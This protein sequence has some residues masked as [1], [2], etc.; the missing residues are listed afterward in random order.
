MTKKPREK[1]AIYAVVDRA[2]TTNWTPVYRWT[3][4]TT[5]DFCIHGCFTTIEEAIADIP[6]EIKKIIIQYGEINHTIIR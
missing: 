1:E 5:R 3:T 2:F 6:L 4:S